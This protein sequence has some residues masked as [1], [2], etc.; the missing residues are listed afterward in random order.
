MYYIDTSVLAAYYCPEALS[1]QV[2]DFLSEQTK[3]AVSNLTELELFSAVAKKVRMGELSQLDGS[4][5]LSKY[6]SHMDAGLFSIIPVEFHHWQ[7]A[8][9]WISLFSTPLRT[10]DA[11]HLAIVSVGDFELVTSDRRLIQ[12]ANILGVKV[13]AMNVD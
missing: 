4:R 13:R 3:P 2:Q 11:L 10:L 1:E 7:L 5:I 9:G 6:L 8:R 12:A